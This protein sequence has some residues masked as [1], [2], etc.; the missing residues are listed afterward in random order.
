MTFLLYCTNDRLNVKVRFWLLL[1]VIVFAVI[2]FPEPDSPIE[3]E[4][5]N[6][7]ELEG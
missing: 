6:W 7:E 4:N 3:S 1:G 5:I 2:T